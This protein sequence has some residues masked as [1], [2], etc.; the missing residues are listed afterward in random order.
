MLQLKHHDVNDEASR[1]YSTL[2]A[3]N[4]LTAVAVQTSRSTFTAGNPARLFDA[5]YA[6]PFPPRQYDVSPDSQRFLMMKD[7]AAGNPNA[8]PASM[9]VALNWHE[10]LRA[11]LRLR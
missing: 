6:T 4:T 5:K 8:T 7:S 2:D 9:V 11:R 3:V 1:W 10:E